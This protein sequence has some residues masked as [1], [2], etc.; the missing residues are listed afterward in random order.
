MVD[1]QDIDAL[2]IGSLYGELTPAEEA[3]LQ[4]HLESHPGDRTAL[5]DLKSAR[6]AVKESRIFDVQAD[7]PQSLSAMLLQEA[8]R[9]APRS[10][11]VREGDGNEGWFARFVRSFMMHP[12]MAAAAMLVIVVGVAGTMYLKNGGEIAERTKSPESVVT[13]PAGQAAPTA[14][15]TEIDQTASDHGGDN[16]QAAQTERAEQQVAAP[17]VGS[18]ASGSAAFHADVADD[19]DFREKVPSETRR[20][21]RGAEKPTTPSY[22]HTSKFDGI[23]VNR[24]EPQPKDLA[25]GEATTLNLGDGDEEGKVAPGRASATGGGAASQTGFAGPTAPAPA[26]APTTTATPAPAQA[27]PPP[28]PPAPKAVSQKA[29]AKTA[30]RA[31][32]DDDVPVTKEAGKQ[33]ENTGLARQLHQKARDAAS[34][35]DC[36]GVARLAAQIQSAAPSYYADTFLTDRALKTCLAYVTNN[37]ERDAPR[38]A[39]KA[40]AAPPPAASPPAATDSAK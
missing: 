2:L 16:A 30:P 24:R 38:K 21:D 13:A 9:R 26:A 27:A 14:Q 37:S 17:A 35:S 11:V 40:K 5:D 39:A 18:T 6:Q 20:T 12:A 23:V 8:H 25:K 32:L 10:K 19:K 33:A 3:R 34:N 7:P 4:T 22:K 1:R 36:N 31:S 28:P 15:P 29:P